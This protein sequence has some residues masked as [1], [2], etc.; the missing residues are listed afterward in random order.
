MVL[1]HLLLA[2]ALHELKHASCCIPNKGTKDRT[3]RC[4]FAS[5][6]VPCAGTNL[7]GFSPG[8]LELLLQLAVPFCL[9]HQLTTEACKARVTSYYVVSQVIDVVPV[10]NDPSLLPRS[11]SLGLIVLLSLPQQLAAQG[12]HL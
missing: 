3:V 5:H 6:D 4:I 7:L 2:Y 8:K 12:S 9:P 1:S 11:Y 10:E